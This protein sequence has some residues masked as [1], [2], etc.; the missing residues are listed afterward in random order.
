M[1]FSELLLLH[2]LF[3]CFLLCF[4]LSSLW[5]RNGVKNCSYHFILLYHATHRHL[6][7]VESSRVI[8]A[9]VMGKP[10]F[11][12]HLTFTFRHRSLKSMYFFTCTKYYVHVIS[13]QFCFFI[14]EGA[15]VSFWARF[16]NKVKSNIKLEIAQSEQD[17]SPFSKESDMTYSWK[18]QIGL[19]LRQ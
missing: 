15:Q 19:F 13:V 4:L 17:V 7:S 12:D 1:G 8:H 9:C 11:L 2:I 14:V 16:I 18:R 5:H 10:C 3:L 6:Y